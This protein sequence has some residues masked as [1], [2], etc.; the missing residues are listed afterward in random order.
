MRK[1]L[2]TSNQKA[3]KIQSRSKSAKKASPL[4]VFAVRA[5]APLLPVVA[6][7]PPALAALELSAVGYP[8]AVALYGHAL[9]HL[10]TFG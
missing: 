10:E 3:L 9:V 2:H 4:F 8:F 5:A 1:T 7:A 6:C